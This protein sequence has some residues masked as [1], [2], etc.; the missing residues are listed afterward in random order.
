MVDA[1]KPVTYAFIMNS[2]PDFGYVAKIT[3]PDIIFK[4]DT[5]EGREEDIV[6]K[7][8]AKSVKIVRDV[9]DHN[10]TTQ[11]IEEA[12]KHVASRTKN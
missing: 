12:A 1:M 7:E 8:Y 11:I 2:V 6:G 5:F 10:S 9:V 3:A 4:S